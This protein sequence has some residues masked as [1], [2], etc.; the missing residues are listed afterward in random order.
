MEFGPHDAVSVDIETEGG[1][2][3]STDD[4][5]PFGLGERWAMVEA[6]VLRLL[7]GDLRGVWNRL[8]I[9]LTMQQVDGVLDRLVAEGRVRVERH[10]E[11]GTVY[12][13]VPVEGALTRYDRILEGVL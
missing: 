5:V 2:R 9:R 8:P 3:F 13:R 12:R 11:R 1:P 7:P 6:E 10:P 4:P